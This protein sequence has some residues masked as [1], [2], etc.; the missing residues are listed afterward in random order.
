MSL[1]TLPLPKPMASFAAKL[2]SA[3]P[4]LALSLPPVRMPLQRISLGTYSVVS[5]DLDAGFF[6]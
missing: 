5:P 3:P 2:T 4:I 6:L 1:R